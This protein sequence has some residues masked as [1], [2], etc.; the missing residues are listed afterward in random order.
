MKSSLAAVLADDGLADML[1]CIQL[2]VFIKG[3]LFRLL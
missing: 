3:M 1:L 2:T